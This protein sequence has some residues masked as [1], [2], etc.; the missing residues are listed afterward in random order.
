[1]KII[2]GALKNRRI[3]FRKNVGVR[4]TRNI[5]KK[6]FFDTIRPVIGNAVFLDLFAGV[7]NM[8][9]EAISQGAR[10]VIM[11]E[12]DKENAYFIRKNVKMLNVADRV[13]IH[14]MDVFSYLET[15]DIRS[16]DIIYADPPYSLEIASFLFSLSDA[17][18]DK[19]ILCVEHSLD[20]KLKESYGKLV[21]LK[22][23]VFSRTVLTYYGSS[24]G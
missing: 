19:A 2:G 11:V 17:M 18:G 13:E 22:E 1:M 23:R 6:S 24:Y 21:R 9:I 12:S 16:I 15:N 20:S 10:R 4:P 5:V 8:G 3:L 7:G 14:R